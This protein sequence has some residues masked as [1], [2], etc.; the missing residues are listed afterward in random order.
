MDIGFGQCSFG[1]SLFGYG[2]TVSGSVAP[3]KPQTASRLIVNKDFVLQQDG[4]AET[5]ITQEMVHWCLAAVK[6]STQIPS[7]GQTLPEVQVITPGVVQEITDI[8]TRALSGPVK[9]G[10]IKIDSILVTP[11]TALNGIRIDV[12]YTDISL[13]KSFT[14]TL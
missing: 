4:L 5:S 2:E 3:T 13:Q 12:A 7:L 10:F 1:E 9:S 8:I 11:I 6:G 14:Y